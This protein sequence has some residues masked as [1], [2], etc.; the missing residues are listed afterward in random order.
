MEL[1]DTVR[2]NALIGLPPPH[3]SQSTLSS[4]VPRCNYYPGSDEI[5]CFIEIHKET[6]TPLENMNLDIPAHTLSATDRD[7]YSYEYSV[8][9]LK[10]TYIVDDRYLHDDT[11]SEEADRAQFLASL[12][13][14]DVI[15]CSC[16]KSGDRNLRTMPEG[17]KIALARNLSELALAW[18]SRNARTP[19]ATQYRH[20]Q[21]SRS[22][23]SSYYRDY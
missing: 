11:L 9:T 3:P 12:T 7:G 1:E 4:R 8:P 14:L 22:R 6:E 19:S 2:N 18:R 15:K 16:W 23:R 17:V 20:P 21:G 10:V 13:P 5:K